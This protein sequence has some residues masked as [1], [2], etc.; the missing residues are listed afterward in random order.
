MKSEKELLNE[1]PNLNLNLNLNLSLNLNLN[2]NL[3]LNL[4]TETAVWN[5]SV[6]SPLCGLWKSPLHP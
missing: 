4:S 5:P 1:P 6:H 3:S 2:L